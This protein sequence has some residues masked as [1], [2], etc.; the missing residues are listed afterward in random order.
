MKLKLTRSQF[1]A[2]YSIFDTIIDNTHYLDGMQA[3]L[4]YSLLYGTFLKLHK[5]TVEKKLEYTL[6]LTDQEAIG[7]W[8]FFEKYPLN[9][10]LPFEVNL[11]QTISNAIHQ[12]FS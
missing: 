4:L 1:D 2:L 6:T 5:K 11:I 7:F 8:L 10:S 3:K 12:K 9:A